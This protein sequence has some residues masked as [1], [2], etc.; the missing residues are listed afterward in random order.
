M[1]SLISIFP[2]RSLSVKIQLRIYNVLCKEMYHGCQ[3]LFKN[4]V[5]KSKTTCLCLKKSFFVSRDLTIFTVNKRSSGKGSSDFSSNIR[6][7]KFSCNLKNLFLYFAN[8]LEKKI[9]LGPNEFVFK[10]K[11]EIS[12]KKFSFDSKNRLPFKLFLTQ[13]ILHKTCFEP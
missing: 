1:M 13:K 8:K 9:D 4:F 12:E 2:S 7:W 3:D 6:S 10:T 11:D 5:T